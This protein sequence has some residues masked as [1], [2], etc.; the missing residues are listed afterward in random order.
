MTIPNA[1][2]RRASNVLSGLNPLALRE[3]HS[4]FDLGAPE[5]VLQRQATMA[6]R[7][8]AGFGRVQVN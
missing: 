1:P 4:A 7:R 2:A 5:R 8:W 3:G 6:R